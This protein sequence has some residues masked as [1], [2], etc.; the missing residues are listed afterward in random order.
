MNG[1]EQT[2]CQA[3]LPGYGNGAGQ[4]L[5]GRKTIAGIIPTAHFEQSGNISD[6]NRLGIVMLP[7]GFQIGVTQHLCIP[8]PQ[9][10][11]EVTFENRGRFW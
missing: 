5:H 2:P 7:Q 11:L 8:V 10:S 6:R 1:L 9:Q 3:C 4:L